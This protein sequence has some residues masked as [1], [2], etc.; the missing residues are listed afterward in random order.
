MQAT[1]Q[2]L[3]Q[4]DDKT[5]I[6]AIPYPGAIPKS[7]ALVDQGGQDFNTFV[8][9]SMTVKDIFVGHAVEAE[10]P[11]LKLQ[12]VMFY[13]GQDTFENHKMY[14][15][16]DQFTKLN[17]MYPLPD[18]SHSGDYVRH[19]GGKLKDHIAAF[20][21]GKVRVWNTWEQDEIDV[22]TLWKEKAH[23]TN[24]SQRFF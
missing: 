22:G 12:D 21:P 24:E 15:I 17:P 14:S 2:L 4:F 19:F 23:K 6:Q 5:K 13:P 1:M 8:K 3:S 16:M 11:E 10:A 7:Q 20:E 18:E 9:N